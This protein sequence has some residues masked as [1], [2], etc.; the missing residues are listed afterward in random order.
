MYMYMYMYMYRL[1]KLLCGIIVH[2]YTHE[3]ASQK[4]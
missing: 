3:V 1:L 4:T 2:I